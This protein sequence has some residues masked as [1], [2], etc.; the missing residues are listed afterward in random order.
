M[1]I[2]VSKNTQNVSA[3]RLSIDTSLIIYDMIFNDTFAMASVR[4]VIPCDDKFE[5][6]YPNLQLLTGDVCM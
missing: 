6:F 5:A 4:V 1:Q 3:I 2:Y